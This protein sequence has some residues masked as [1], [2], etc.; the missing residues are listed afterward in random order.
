[1]PMH[2]LE[3]EL[4]GQRLYFSPQQEYLWQY[5]KNERVT[6]A[7]LKNLRKQTWTDATCGWVANDAGAGRAMATIGSAGLISFFEEKQ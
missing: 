7:E 6:T 1:M 5:S 3:S 4:A 2:A